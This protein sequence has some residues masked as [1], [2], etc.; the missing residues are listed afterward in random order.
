MSQ[1]SQAF[2]KSIKNNLITRKLVHRYVLIEVVAIQ[3]NK[4]ILWLRFF[5]R[6]SSQSLIYPLPN[7]IV[8]ELS[9]FYSY[10]LLEMIFIDYSKTVIFKIKV[11]CKSNFS[12]KILII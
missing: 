10:I 11:L 2:Q 6:S 5:G 12:Y 3:D 8:N 4:M 9:I 1:A 7:T